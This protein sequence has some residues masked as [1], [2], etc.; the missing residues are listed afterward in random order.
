MVGFNDK[1]LVAGAGFEPTTLVMSIYSFSDHKRR[2]S[3]SS[4]LNW[5]VYCASCG[6]PV[7][8]GGATLDR[9]ISIDLGCTLGHINSV[10]PL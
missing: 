9:F 6:F 10:S 4:G 2:N 3:I 1:N 8:R 5:V 7:I